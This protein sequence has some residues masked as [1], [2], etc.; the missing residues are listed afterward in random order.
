VY[1]FLNTVKV[2]LQSIQIVNLTNWFER[3][4]KPCFYKKNFGFECPGC[5]F[6]RAFI[7]LLQG[8][9]WESIKQY[10]ALLPLLFMIAM[11]LFHL[12]FRLRHGALIILILFILSAVL[13]VGNYMLKLTLN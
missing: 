6:Q 7:E 9:I 12:K 13:I 4:G 2:Q 1:Y 11:L 5:G 3:H 10:P 8:N